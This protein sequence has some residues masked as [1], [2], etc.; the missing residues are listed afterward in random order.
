MRNRG[1]LLAIL[2]LSIPASIMVTGIILNSKRT[3]DVTRE[4]LRRSIVDGLYIDPDR[5]HFAIGEVENIKVRISPS[6]MGDS[7][8][9]V[10]QVGNNRSESVWLIPNRVSFLISPHFS[11][12]RLY[13]IQAHEDGRDGPLAIEEQEI[14]PKSERYFHFSVSWDARELPSKTNTELRLVFR[15]TEQ[16]ETVLRFPFVIAPLDSYGVPIG[17]DPANPQ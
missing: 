6:G 4:P 11:A 16:K 2:A 8:Y 10:A 12:R 17:V 3:Q 15:D 7:A 13:V 9:F 1:T 14:L 5:R